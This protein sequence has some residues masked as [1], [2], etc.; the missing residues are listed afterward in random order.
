MKV[1]LAFVFTFRISTKNLN[2]E[3][4]VVWEDSRRQ[5]TAEVAASKM[6]VVHAGESSDLVFVFTTPVDNLGECRM[7]REGNTYIVAISTPKLVGNSKFAVVE[8][9][10]IFSG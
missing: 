9:L 5:Q 6:D 4:V 8:H 7:V 2:G 3:T 1:Y 10:D